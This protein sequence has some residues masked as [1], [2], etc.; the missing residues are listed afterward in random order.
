MRG[1]N[2]DL[3]TFVFANQGEDPPRIRSYLAAEGLDPARRPG[4]TWPA[5]SPAGPDGG[6]IG[7]DGLLKHAHLGEISP[8][9][10]RRR[11]D[12]LGE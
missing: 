8:E 4:R 7:R 10:F 1:E 12:E 2:V 6:F 5:L 3:G 11:I 9:E